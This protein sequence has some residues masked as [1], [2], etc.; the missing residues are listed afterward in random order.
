[1][2]SFTIPRFVETFSSVVNVTVHLKGLKTI[3][4]LTVQLKM[5]EALSLEMF[6]RGTG[7]GHHYQRKSG[8]NAWNIK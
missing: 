3:V 1:M 4:V 2:H 8:I 7:S 5:V 6:T